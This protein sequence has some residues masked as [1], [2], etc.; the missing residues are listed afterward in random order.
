MVLDIGFLHLLDKARVAEPD[1][2]VIDWNEHKENGI[3]R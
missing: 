3:Q 2:L 1:E